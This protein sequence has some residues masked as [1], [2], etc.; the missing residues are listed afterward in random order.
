MAC[1]APS[2]R[3]N[4]GAVSK[5]GWLGIGGGFDDPDAVDAEFERFVDFLYRAS[6]AAGMLGDV[7][8][9]GDVDT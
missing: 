3:P 9:V 6:S 4:V 5:G 1:G 2:E 8:D 7:G